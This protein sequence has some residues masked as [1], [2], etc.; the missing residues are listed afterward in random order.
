M[1][2]AEAFL[3]DDMFFTN[4]NVEARSGAHNLALRRSWSPISSLV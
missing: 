3:S 2:L 4:H 1:A